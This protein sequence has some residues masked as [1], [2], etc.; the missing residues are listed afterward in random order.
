MKQVFL[1]LLREKRKQDIE[2]S[3]KWWNRDYVVDI[4]VQVFFLIKAFGQNIELRVKLPY[5]CKID[6]TVRMCRQI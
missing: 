3:T 4:E 1:P 2:T 6:Q 5:L